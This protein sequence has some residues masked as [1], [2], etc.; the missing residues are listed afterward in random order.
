MNALNDILQQPFVVRLGWALIHFLWQGSAIAVLLAITQVV[1]KRRAAQARYLAGCAALATMLIAPLITFALLPNISAARGGVSTFELA[2][3]M[4]SSPASVTLPNAVSVLTQASSSN[5]DGTIPWLVMAWVVGVCVLS[6]R[7]LG[8]WLHLRRLRTRQAEEIGEPWIGKFEQLKRR[9]GISRPVQLLKSALVEVPTV[10]G[11]LRPVILLPAS[12]ITGLTPGQLESVLAHELAHVRRN[13]YLVNLIQRIIETLLFYHPAV[14]WVSKCIREERELCCDDVVVHMCGDR[15]NYARAL[16]SLEQF[17]WARTDLALAASGGSLAQR[18]RRLLKKSSAGEPP[19]WRRPLLLLLIGAALVVLTA[20]PS[21]MLRP[22]LY[23]STVRISIAKDPDPSQP[24]G[25]WTAP[26]DRKSFDPY[27]IQTEFE[28]IKSRLVLY[29]VIEKLGLNERWAKRFGAEDRLK[30]SD[31][32]Q[33]LVKNVEMRQSRNTSL[34]EIKVFSKQPREAAEIANEIARTYADLRGSRWRQAISALQRQLKEQKEESYSAGKKMDELRLSLGVM[35]SANGEVLDTSSPETLRVFERERAEVEVKIATFEG[36]LNKLKKTPRDLLANSI[37]TAAYPDPRLTE[38][39][40][41]LD[42]AEV[43]RAQLSDELANDHSKVLAIKSTIKTIREQIENRVSAIL[44]QLQI[45]VERH[46]EQLDFLTR[47]ISEA[48][49]SHA[50]AAE[51]Y[52][53][54]FE[55]KRDYEAKQRLSETLEL[56]I[57]Q[58]TTETRLPNYSVE[59]VDQAEPALRPVRGWF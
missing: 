19:S 3:A 26:D 24:S 9:L 40:S 20:W 46:G 4:S 48:R 30:T 2:T 32:F 55:A 39:L 11:W 42:L 10:I 5:V 29:T 52:R 31:T 45:E 58:E 17:R 27:W 41:Q 13:D 14:W 53:P 12:T 21:L 22:K 33:L 36:L 43:T 15:L 18:I 50:E 25:P 47:K 56:R 54:Y 8:G 34:I 6:V 35:E 44:S 51:K 59:V 23:A 1:L 28:K 38:L 37:P 7:L 16:A 49:K 57:R